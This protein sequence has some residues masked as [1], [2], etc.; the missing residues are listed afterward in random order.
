M[1]ASLTVDAV[2]ARSNPGRAV[3]CA[4]VPGQNTNC[5]YLLRWD[6]NNRVSLLPGVNTKGSAWSRVR[7]TA[8]IFSDTHPVLI[9]GEVTK[10][11]LRV[12]TNIAYPLH[13]NMIELA[14]VELCAPRS[15][16]MGG[17]Q[18]AREEDGGRRNENVTMDVRCH[19]VGQDQKR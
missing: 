4:C 15:G 10:N 12:Y 3:A 2:V 9:Q 18:G 17:E 16:D 7:I 13:S 14:M 8:G 19:Y 6:T 11:P 1:V 5:R